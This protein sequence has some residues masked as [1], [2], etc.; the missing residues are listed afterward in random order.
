M[1]QHRCRVDIQLAVEGGPVTFY[2]FYREPEFRG[3]TFVR[4]A[5]AEEH[6][7]LVFPRCE[8]YGVP[9]TRKNCIRPVF[10]THGSLVVVSFVGMVD[11]WTRSV[12]DC[13]DHQ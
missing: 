6:S 4:L 7:N 1:N 12:E 5:P 8:V 13:K 2:G 10:V 11:Q 9:S 3:A